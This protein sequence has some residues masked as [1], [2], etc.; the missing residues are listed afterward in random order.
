LKTKRTNRF[1]SCFLTAL[2]GTSVFCLILVG[3]SVISNLVLPSHSVDTG[4][5]TELD[6]ARLAEADHLRQV[7][8][9]SVW[10]GF[11]EA[12]IPI[13]LY[14]EQYAFL[15]GL[16]DPEPGW[17]KVPANEQ[18]GGP[19]QVVQG[20]TYHGEPYFRQQLSDPQS[21]PEAFTVLVGDQWVASMTTKEWTEIGL[22]E[23]IR[24]DFPPLLQPI[25]PFKLFSRLLVGDSDRYIS[26]ILHESFHAYEGQVAYNRLEAAE[27]A[28]LNDGERY[29]W[30]SRALQED[31]KTEIDYLLKAFH[32]S[33]YDETLH[34]VRQFLAQRDQ[35][36]TGLAPGMVEYERLREMEEGL[37]KYVQ[38]QLL[39]EAAS[40][41]E[42]QPVAE[43]QLDNDFNGY[44]TAEKFFEQEISNTKTVSKDARFYYTGMLQAF[45]LDRLV[46]GWKERIFQD[47]LTLESLLYEAV[48]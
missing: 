40:T 12:T 7:L 27:R 38:L 6:K 28:M 8:G 19:W 34:F 21:S 3:V 37:A 33:S 29:P 43:M 13:I 4:Y 15:V 5:L 9:D 35:R 48:Q 41:S 10:P 17:I 18:R 30:D 31:W 24:Q 14:N 32:S 36:R 11:G 16:S 47:E 46:P 20:D 2:L 42:Y 25:L 45:L 1:R 22:A 39:L 26:L 44:T 23:P